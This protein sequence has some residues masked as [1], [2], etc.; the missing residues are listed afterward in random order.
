MAQNSTE[1]LLR[2]LY[3]TIICSSVVCCVSSSAAWFRWGYILN[4]HPERNCGCYLN[5]RTLNSCSEKSCI[6][7]VDGSFEGGHNVYCL[8]ATLGLVL[9]LLVFGLMTYDYRKLIGNEREIAENTSHS[10]R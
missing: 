7:D 8:F 1:K 3:Y 5:S 6:C 9:P 10:Q 4:K 2:N